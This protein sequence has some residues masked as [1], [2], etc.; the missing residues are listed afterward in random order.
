METPWEVAMDRWLGRF[1][2]RCYALLRIVA[3]FLFACH[4][5]QKLFGALGGIDGQG[6]IAPFFSLLGAAGIIE[7]F[8]G[9]LIAVGL[10][11][12]PIAFI[13][14]G[15]MAFAYFI[16]HFPRGWW[17][18]TNQGELAALYCFV[19]LM[20]AARGTGIWSLDHALKKS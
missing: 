7:F 15:E 16:R 8:G 20:L 10:A 19:W 9:T 2:D 14:S 13:A 3:G 5:A 1:A 6:A 11:A 12:R 4:G 17:P 18:L